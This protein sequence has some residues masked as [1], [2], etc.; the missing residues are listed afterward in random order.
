MTRFN[1]FDERDVPS[2]SRAES[3]KDGKMFRHSFKKIP[4]TGLT[5][6]TA[7]LFLKYGR[8]NTFKNIPVPPPPHV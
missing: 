3:L 8:R 2:M 6:K 7:C 5:D 4:F 1:H